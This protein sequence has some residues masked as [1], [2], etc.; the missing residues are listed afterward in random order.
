M[1]QAKECQSKQINCPKNFP[2]VVCLN[3]IIIYSSV[4][5]LVSKPKNT[6]SISLANKILIKINY[7][8]F[9][10][11]SPIK[12]QPLP[13]NWNFKSDI[14]LELPEILLALSFYNRVFQRKREFVSTIRNSF[15]KND[16]TLK[17]N[18][19]SRKSTIDC[20]GEH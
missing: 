11:A 14:P 5:S 3:R 15:G 2:C 13:P 19:Y 1:T 8:S 10:R 9:I 17:T 7:R 6:C 20:A 16:C 4:S 18:Q 12:S